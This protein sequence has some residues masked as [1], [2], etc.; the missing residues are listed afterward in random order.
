[1]HAVNLQKY[2]KTDKK[3]IIIIIIYHLYEE[4]LQLYTCNI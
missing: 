2:R 1:M 4:H 3:Y